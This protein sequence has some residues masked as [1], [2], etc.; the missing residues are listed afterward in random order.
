M[1]VLHLLDLLLEQLT[2]KL[3][4]VCLLSVLIIKSDTR[5]NTLSFGVILRH[6]L[7]HIVITCFTVS[8][9]FNL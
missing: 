6:D 3:L 9:G 8:D 5:L 7:H 4:V 1:D 2:G